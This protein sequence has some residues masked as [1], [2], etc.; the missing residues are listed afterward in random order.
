MLIRVYSYSF[1]SENVLSGALQ[2]QKFGFERPSDKSGAISVDGI[3]LVQ[4]LLA[5][6]VYCV[7]IVG[8]VVL[9]VGPFPK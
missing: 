1:L 7:A 8:V 2:E 4:I 6:E 5:K 9:C 3:D